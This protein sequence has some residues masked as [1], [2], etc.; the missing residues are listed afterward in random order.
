MICMLQVAGCD[1]TSDNTRNVAAAFP[2]PGLTWLINGEFLRIPD[3]DRIR[4]HICDV[5]QSPVT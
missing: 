1:V 4:G 3:I 5:M 2:F